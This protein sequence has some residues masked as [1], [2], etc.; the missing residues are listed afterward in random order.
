MLGFCTQP[1]EIRAAEPPA[2]LDSQQAPVVRLRDELRL[3]T[4]YLEIERTRFGSRL[5]FQIDAPPELMS[6]SIT[7]TS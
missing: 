1:R 7:W 4:D 6:I 3:V 2:H 5:R